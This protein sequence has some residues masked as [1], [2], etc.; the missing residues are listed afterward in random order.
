M[1]GDVQAMNNADANYVKIR[2]SYYLEAYGKA[3]HLEYRTTGVETGN[4]QMNGAV[5]NTKYYLKFKRVNSTCT[6]YIYS[7]SDRTILLDTLSVN[8]NNVK[9]RYLYVTC[10]RN[11]GHA[12]RTCDVINTNYDLQETPPPTGDKWIPTYFNSKFI[13]QH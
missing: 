7:D 2:T 9:Y 5:A 12:N 8:A 3:I 10:T 4:D 13:T 6:L 1:I 11:T